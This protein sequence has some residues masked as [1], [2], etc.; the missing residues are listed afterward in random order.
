MTTKEILGKVLL[1]HLDRR[2]VM[3]KDPKLE[4]H[5]VTMTFSAWEYFREGMT[6]DEIKKPVR[7]LILEIA[8]LAV[9]DAMN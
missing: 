8:E 6:E 4:G 7:R 5:R 3:T 1:E 9:L 2:P